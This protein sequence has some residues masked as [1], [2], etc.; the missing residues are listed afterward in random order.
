M[1]AAPPLGDNPAMGAG[2]RPLAVPL[3][4]V[5]GALSYA[6]DLTEGSRRAT[7]CGRA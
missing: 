5:I 7:R 4:D 1:Y 3:S 2:P 6:L